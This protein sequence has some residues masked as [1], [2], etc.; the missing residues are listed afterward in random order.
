MASFKNMKPFTLTIPEPCSE[1][2]DNM[3]STADGRFCSSCRKTV[4]DF[5]QMDDTELVAFFR[6]R[7]AKP[8]CGRFCETQL[9]RVFNLPESHRPPFLYHAARIAASVLLLQTLIPAANAQQKR[10]HPTEQQAPPSGKDNKPVKGRVTDAL[11]GKGLAG[12]TVSVTG[13][14]TVV[15]DKNGNF[16]FLPD[17]LPE[18]DTLHFKAAWSHPADAPADA[19]F[20]P[21]HIRR[22]E[23][24]RSGA[25]RLQLYPQK[26][27][28]V[29]PVT[30]RV[31]EPVRYMRMGAVHLHD[32]LRI[33]PKKKKK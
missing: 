21:L 23:L 8:V 29:L 11:S 12:V 32:D 9:D 26:E 3:E 15:T 20:L 19:A 28:D 22:E 14:P 5:S 31:V 13:G 16:S 33:K 7:S 6:E 10:T 18:R 27:L 25:I 17:E 24:E 30:T 2:W 4:V 1:R